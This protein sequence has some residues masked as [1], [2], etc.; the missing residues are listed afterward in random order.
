MQDALGPSQLMTTLFRIF[1]FVASG[2]QSV[3]SDKK[4]EL[5]GI[6]AVNNR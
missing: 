3:P 6:F 4:G 5:E 1:H 2:Y